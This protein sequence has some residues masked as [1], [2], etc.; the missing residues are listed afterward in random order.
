MQ[1]YSSAKTAP[2]VTACLAS[3]LSWLV[4]PS[5]IP[6]PGNRTRIMFSYAGRSMVDFVVIDGPARTVE[7]RAA[8]GYKDRIKRDAESC[9]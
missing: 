7:V 9:V 4:A 2:E 6:E 5:V 1:T 3:K 8:G